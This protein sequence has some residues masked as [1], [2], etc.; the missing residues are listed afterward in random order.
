MNLKD[1]F[2][3]PEFDVI[4]VVDSLLEYHASKSIMLV[5]IGVIIELFSIVPKVTKFLMLELC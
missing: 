4:L 1:Q 3:L 5:F 2:E